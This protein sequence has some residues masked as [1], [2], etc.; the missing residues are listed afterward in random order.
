MFDR[1]GS[2]YLSYQ[3]QSALLRVE[4]KCPGLPYGSNSGGPDYID[5]SIDLGLGVVATVFIALTIRDIRRRRNPEY[6]S[7]NEDQE[8]DEL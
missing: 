4:A 6:S 7:G 2:E 5:I 3:F 8:S 1:A